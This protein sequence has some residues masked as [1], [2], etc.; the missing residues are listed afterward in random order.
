VQEVV[1]LVVEVLVEEEVPSLVV[2]VEWAV[3]E[4][5]SRVIQAS[6][7]NL[8]LLARV[9]L[10]MSLVAM[11]VELEGWVVVEVELQSVDHHRRLRLLLNPHVPHNHVLLHRD[12]H[13]R[14]RVR[15]L[16]S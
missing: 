3:V 2:E 4:S 11:E 8:V 13:L 12:H 9:V 5:K 16:I 1:V 7:H 6:F 15:H 14:L 10:Q